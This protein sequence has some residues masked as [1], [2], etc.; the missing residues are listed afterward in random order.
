MQK[1]DFLPQERE[2]TVGNIPYIRDEY[3][4]DCPVIQFADSVC[5]LNHRMSLE[6]VAMSFMMFEF[7]LT[8]QK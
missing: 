6:E 5:G 7:N 3:L 2:G 1:L 4:C 8:S